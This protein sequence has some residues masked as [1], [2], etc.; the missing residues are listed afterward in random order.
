MV[1]K[2]VT[3]IRYCFDEYIDHMGLG[4]CFV[5]R[6]KERE[7]LCR[8]WLPVRFCSLRVSHQFV[9]WKT[10]Q[11][12]FQPLVHQTVEHT[13][14]LTVDV[15][16]NLCLCNVGRISFLRNFVLI[17]YITDLFSSYGKEYVILIVILR[18]RIHGFSPWCSWISKVLTIR[19][20]SSR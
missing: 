5:W 13:L 7:I 4:I 16:D 12:V 11:N 20:L 2:R 15:C 18:I 8:C 9:Q 1:I 6:M 14:Q 3:D 19:L 10:H 17:L